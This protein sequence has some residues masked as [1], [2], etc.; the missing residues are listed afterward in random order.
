LWSTG[1]PGFCLVRFVMHCAAVP[2][3]P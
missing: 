3:C 1:L 2:S